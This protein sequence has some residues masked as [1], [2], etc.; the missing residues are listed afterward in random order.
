VRAVPTTDP[1]EPVG[2]LR[3]ASRDARDAR[4]AE[5]QDFLGYGPGERKL[6]LRTHALWCHDF[7]FCIAEVLSASG[8]G[9]I[10]PAGRRVRTL[11][12]MATKMLGP[13]RFPS[14][15]AARIQGALGAERLLDAVES[16]ERSD[17]LTLLSLE[18]SD[19]VLTASAKWLT[20][21]ARRLGR[22]PP[23]LRLV[24]VG[25]RESALSQ[26]PVLWIDLPEP[27]LRYLDRVDADDNALAGTRWRKRGLDA[28]VFR[29]EALDLEFT[30]A[31][32]TDLVAEFAFEHWLL[33]RTLQKRADA[34]EPWMDELVA[35]LLPAAWLKP[36]P[37]PVP[38]G[39]RTGTGTGTGTDGQAAASK[40]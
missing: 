5:L 40:N 20:D 25:P 29:D 4:D 6:D 30:P 26:D 9:L 35:R 2:S 18:R 12:A 38:A 22:E 10:A 15:D 24:N 33:G 11:A 27:V 23:A 39:T 32:A 28:D 19:A 1:T 13:E 36:P 34:G 8:G 16:W 31:G 17:E 3:S 14:L 7:V 37:V 21:Q